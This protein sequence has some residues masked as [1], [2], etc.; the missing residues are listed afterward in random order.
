M[1]VTVRTGGVLSDEMSPTEEIHRRSGT[2]TR[3]SASIAARGSC[4]ENAGLLGHKAHD[5]FLSVNLASGEDAERRSGRRR[6]NVRMATPAPDELTL[7]D[8][9]SVPAAITVEDDVV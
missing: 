1:D 7:A 5:R 6:G 9:R 2:W 3:P 8:A 4:C